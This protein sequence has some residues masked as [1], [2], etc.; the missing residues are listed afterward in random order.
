MT[1]TT[2]FG[3]AVDEDALRGIDRRRHEALD[4]GRVGRGHPEVQ[5]QLLDLAV[6]L[7]EERLALVLGQGPGQLVPACLDGVAIRS[8]AAPRSNGEVRPQAGAAC[9][10]SMARRA[11]SRPPFESVPIRAPV[12]GLVASNVWPETAVPSG[13]R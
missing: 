13:R 4:A 7:G 2:P 9:A 8:R 1:P 12:A 11:S 6:G 5:D 3:H 10:A